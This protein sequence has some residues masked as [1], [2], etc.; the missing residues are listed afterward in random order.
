MNPL[1]GLSDVIARWRLRRIAKRRI[2]EMLPRDNVREGARARIFLCVLLPI[3][4]RPG[5]PES[6]LPS[7]LGDRLFGT[8]RLQPKKRLQHAVPEESAAMDGGFWRRGGGERQ[9]RLP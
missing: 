6:V 5:L 4:G 8:A 9:W 1:R 2:R 7:Q 3:S